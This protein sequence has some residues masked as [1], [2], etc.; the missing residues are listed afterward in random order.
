MIRNQ[1]FNTFYHQFEKIRNFN[2]HIFVADY[3]EQTRY[4]KVK[5][6]VEFFCTNSPTDISFFSI[7]N[8]EKVSIDGIDFDNKSFVHLVSLFL[9]VNPYSFQIYQKKIPGFCFVN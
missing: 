5:R 4:N 1:I 2:N 7:I 8:N 9:N 3:T 6:S